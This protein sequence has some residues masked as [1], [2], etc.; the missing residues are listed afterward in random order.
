LYL[1]E[2]RDT[3]LVRIQDKYEAIDC[4]R[5]PHRIFD[6]Q[7]IRIYSGKDVVELLQ[8]KEFY[9]ACLSLFP[10]L[11]DEEINAMFQYSCEII[12]AK[13]L[14][15]CIEEGGWREISL[16]SGKTLYVNVNRKRLQWKQ[17]YHPSS[18]RDSSSCDIETFV[19]VALQQ[20][21]LFRG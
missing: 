16:S 7:H 6:A 8:P 19:S 10:G 2:A 4:L 9:Y 15:A 1:F 11:T 5:R 12:T 17:P 18:F 3:E 21:L 20:K 14:R 13:S